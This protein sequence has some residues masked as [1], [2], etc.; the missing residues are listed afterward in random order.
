MHKKKGTELQRCFAYD[1]LKDLCPEGV[2]YF[3]KQ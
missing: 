2:V 3:E 1:F